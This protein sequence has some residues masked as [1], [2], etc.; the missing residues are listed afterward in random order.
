MTTDPNETNPY[1]SPVTATRP[2]EV[3]VPSPS[4][5]RRF[6]WRVIPVT[7][8]YLYGGGVIAG[9]LGIV[10]ATLCLAVFGGDRFQSRIGLGGAAVCVCLICPGAIALGCLF[11]FA[12]RSLWQGR[13]RR[14]I[15]ATILAFAIYGGVVAVTQLLGLK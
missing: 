14:G 6:R 11:L 4:V 8:L 10:F 1:R 7:L 3:A 15:A 2:V 13:W 12:G 9:G 5:R